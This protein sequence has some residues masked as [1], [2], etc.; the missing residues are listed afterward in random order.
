MKFTNLLLII[1]IT[2]SSCNSKKNQSISSTESPP[3]KLIIDFSKKIRSNTSLVLDAYGINIGLH[4]GFNYKNGI[5]NLSASYYLKKS[6]SDEVTLESARNLLVFL[7][8]SFKEEIL[9]NQ[10]ISQ[11]LD[12]YQHL[13]DLMRISIYFEDENRIELGQG[14]SHIFFLRGEIKYEG[15]NI[16][17]YT[18]KFP[19]RG[20]HYIIH[21]EK[22][23]DALDIV[24]KQ[25]NLKC[26]SLN[27]K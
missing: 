18:G 26:L 21:E 23:L 25:G 7:T 19:A 17:E 8:E 1:I 20:K 4:H 6:K 24:K 16:S 13:S 5:G 11:Y 22:Y 2:L 3:Y 15:Y 10:E 9:A 27:Q 14:V 12:P